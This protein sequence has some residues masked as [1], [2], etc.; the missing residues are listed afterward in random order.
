MP[1][2]GPGKICEKNRRFSANSS[3]RRLFSVTKKAGRRSSCVTYD[4]I[5]VF[6][7]ARETHQIAAGAHFSLH[8]LHGRV[9]QECFHPFSHR[10]QYQN[11]EVGSQEFVVRSPISPPALHS[12]L[13]G[14][15]VNLLLTSLPIQLSRIHSILYV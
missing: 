14:P 8:A 10:R 12:P 11:L 15:R 6:A 13:H 7:T 4:A 2:V 3:A 9:A 5:S 1:P